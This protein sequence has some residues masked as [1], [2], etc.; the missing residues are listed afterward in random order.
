MVN[1]QSDTLHFC[2]SMDSKYVARGLVMYESLRR[3]CPDF[4]LYI[5]AYDEVA[6]RMLNSLALEYVT[7]VPLRDIEDADLLRVKPSRTVQEYCWTGKP[8]LI[9]HIL[10]KF[11]V[12]LCS[13]IDAD[14][15]FHANPK[16]LI[17]EMG[18]DSILITEHRYS[19]GFNLSAITGIY[20]TQLI[21]F[22][23]DVRGL[24]AL[25]WWRSACLDWCSALPADGKFGD[26]KYLDD[27]PIRF[28]GVCVLQNR[29]GGVAPWNIQ[30]YTICQGT[31]NII[32]HDRRAGD[33]FD[34]IFYHFHFVR[35][36]EDG[37]VDLG[38]FHLSP[39]VKRLMYVPYLNALET[40][41]RR[42]SKV[43]G[44]FDPRAVRN[45]P[46]GLKATF[47][48]WKRRLRGR[49]NVLRPDSLRQ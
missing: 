2:V 44:D 37:T 7:V 40:A 34:L 8:S 3:F 36:Y 33:E 4:H 17:D 20:C 46:R 38:E 11:G 21:S 9:L 13:F 28:D 10:E 16:M 35:F 25:H 24:K 41:I 15:D 12:P 31:E 45:R 47:N 6:E 30:R 42:A 1:T 39:A 48:A 49:Y 22:R 27:W 19:P 14:L 18:D 43:S 26:Q 5:C 32:L 29:G 23:N